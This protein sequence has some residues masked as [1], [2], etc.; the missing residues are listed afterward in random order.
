MELRDDRTSV[1]Q[2]VGEKGV[3]YYELSSALELLP[4]AYKISNPGENI[5]RAVEAEFKQYGVK[6]LKL[7][8]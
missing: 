3:P 5:A 6:A 1:K 8:D 2:A 4:Q 7:I